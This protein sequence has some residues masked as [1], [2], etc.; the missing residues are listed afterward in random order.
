[1]PIV[2]FTGKPGHW[3]DTTTGVEYR[4]LPDGTM[5]AVKSGGASHVS[6]VGGSI[7]DENGVIRTVQ[8]S[9][10]DATASGNTE[11][12]AAQGTGIKIRVI[13]L[14]HVSLT[15][16]TVKFQSA[17]TSKS[18]GVPAAANGGLVLPRNDHG[19]FETAANEA[20]N[21]NL[22]AAVATGVMVDWIP[23]V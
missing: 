3:Y 7:I 6:N 14:Y 20:L 17:T 4:Q 15:A 11:V 19:W 18:P 23:V 2:Q 5:E 1:M 8:R 12:V 10:L 22:S 16:V 13:A 21:V 9:F